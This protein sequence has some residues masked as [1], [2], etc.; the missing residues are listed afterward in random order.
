MRTRV[1]VFLQNRPFLGALLVHIPLLRAL[2]TAYPGARI[3]VYSPFA[4]A[5][6]LVTLKE[7]DAVV[8]YGRAGSTPLPVVLR[9]DRPDVVLT[10][11]RKSL[12]VALAIAASGAR[13]TV[14]FRHPI[15]DRL[16]D[17]R[18]P[19]DKSVYRALSALRLLA[20][21]CVGVDVSDARVFRSDAA[22]TPREARGVC[23][24]PCA[25]DDRK[26]WG[27]ERYLDLCRRLRSKEGDAAVTFILGPRERTL[28]P[29]IESANLGVPVSLLVEGS[30]E[31]IANAVLGARLTVTNDCAPGHV[32]QMAGGPVVCVFGNWDGA[33]P[34]RMGEWFYRRPGAAAVTTDAPGPITDVTVEAVL[35]AARGLMAAETGLSAPR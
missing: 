28:V 10:L 8:L 19:L 5:S 7:A 30:V 4:G 35:A 6:L 14:G 21:L 29:A 31:D 3:H 20:P 17:H 25:S 34:R 13:T 1:A 9:R 22:P 11:R 16:Y 33:A 24:V 27:I 32:A 23:V 26:Q 15:L 18:I 12:R 2:R